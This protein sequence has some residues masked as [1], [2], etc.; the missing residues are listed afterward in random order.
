VAALHDSLEY[1]IWQLDA[2]P[3]RRGELA[4]SRASG[5]RVTA[6]EAT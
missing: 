4:S 5:S 3:E 6:Q 1:A 2:Q